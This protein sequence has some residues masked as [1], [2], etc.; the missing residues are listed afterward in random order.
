V[1]VDALGNPFNLVLTPGQAHDLTAA[2][3]LL[4]SAH[5]SALIG[6]KAY[7]TDALI[8]ALNR[9]HITAVMVLASFV[10]AKDHVVAIGAGRSSCQIKADQ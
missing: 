10:G 2:E 4:E 9:R 1:L 5:P 7:D 8:N 6:D 3:R